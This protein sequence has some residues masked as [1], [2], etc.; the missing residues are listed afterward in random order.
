MQLE[1]TVNEYQRQATVL[2]IASG[3]GGVGK[4]NIAANLALC[5][6]ASGRKIVL[7]DAD[8]GLANL[9]VIMGINSR[10]NIAD[11]LEDK[12][13]I[14]Q[15]VHNSHDNIDVVCGASGLESLADLN[16][17]QQNRLLKELEKLQSNA[18]MII[19]DTAAGIGKSVA[20]F[21]LSADRTLVVTT[22]DPAAITDAYA[23]IKVL[24]SNGYRGQI[25]LAVNMADSARQADNIFNQVANVVR[26][27]LSVELHRAGSV[28]KDERLV[29]A[30][31]NR[32]PVVQAYPKSAAALSLAAMAAKLGKT[33]RPYAQGEGFFRKVANWFS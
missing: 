29:T 24:A 23:M 2:A 32:Q 33:C 16:Q 9:D 7:I 5:M 15:I 30:V 31:R 4:T 20:A 19:I 8:W 25:S 6:A 13:N 17:F 10:Y 11:V 28:L 12:K 18:D 22:P 27:F 1:H 26:R 14:E 21:C 3:K